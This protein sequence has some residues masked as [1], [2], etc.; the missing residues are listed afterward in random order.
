MSTIA[1]RPVRVV[2]TGM[3]VPSRTLDNH[4]LSRMVD[5][6]DQW[7]IER[8]GI[9]VRHIASDGENAS[10]FAAGAC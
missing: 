5:T 4:D 9:K 2:S 6:T 8:T 7:I 3:A 10:D 1:G